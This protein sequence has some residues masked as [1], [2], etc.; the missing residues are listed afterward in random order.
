MP[1]NSLYN[2]CNI[3]FIDIIFS[4]KL[5]IWWITI[6]YYAK[7][8]L[9]NLHTVRQCLQNFIWSQMEFVLWFLEVR[10]VQDLPTLTGHEQ[11][12]IAIITSLYC[13]KL[14]VD[15]M[16]EDKTTYVKYKT[17]GNTDDKSQLFPTIWSE[18]YL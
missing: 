8:L 12:T 10:I 14:A 1:S 3:M 9:N 7:I 17:E 15:A 16:I 13:E 2:G 18:T 4:A 11:P 5:E 6:C